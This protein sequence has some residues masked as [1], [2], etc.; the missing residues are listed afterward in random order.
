MES[1]EKGRNWL[2]PTV[3]RKD[4]CVHVIAEPRI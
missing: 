3:A 1:G 4:V 2:N